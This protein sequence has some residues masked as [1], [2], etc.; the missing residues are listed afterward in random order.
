MKNRKLF[1]KRL[2]LSILG[3]AIIGFIWFSLFSVLTPIYVLINIIVWIFTGKSI[4][5]VSYID[6]VALLFYNKLKKTKLAKI[7]NDIF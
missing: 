2:V 1:N 5:Y 3:L 4:T 6:K 7:W